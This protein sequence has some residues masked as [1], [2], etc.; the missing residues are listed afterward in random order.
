MK[1]LRG[2]LAQFLV[3]F[4]GVISPV[5]FAEL[6]QIEA[7]VSVDLPVASAWEVMS[8]FS[9]AQN[10]VPNLSG[11][12]IMSAERSGVGAHRRAYDMDGGYIEET[13]ISWHEGQGLVLK[14]HKGD[15]PMSPFKQIE[16]TY[17]L[18]EVNESE[19]RIT[20]S[21]AYELPLGVVGAKLG[22]WFISPVMQKTLVLTAAGMK[23]YYETGEPATDEDR[24]RLAGAVR[25]GPA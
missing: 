11:T 22:E 4:G 1:R 10:Y 21:M 19:A 6:Q 5:A 24:E 12:E 9:I 17:R 13:I 7:S 25:A 20:I 2:L 8:D 18:S 15:E 23:H 16:F 14:L 3:I